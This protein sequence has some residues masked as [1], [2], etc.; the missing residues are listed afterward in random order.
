MNMQYEELVLKF[1][2][3]PHYRHWLH[4]WAY[5]F[6]CILILGLVVILLFGLEACSDRQR[7]LILGK[8]KTRLEILC[9]KVLVL[10]RKVLMKSKIGIVIA[11][12]TCY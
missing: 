11:L 7:V 1:A 5:F 2:R 12:P 4:C 9:Q 6:G 3:K 10:N 8:V